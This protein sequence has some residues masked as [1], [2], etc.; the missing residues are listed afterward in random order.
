MVLKAFSFL[1]KV[2]KAEGNKLDVREAK[3]AVQAE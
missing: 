3:R 2:K 1:C